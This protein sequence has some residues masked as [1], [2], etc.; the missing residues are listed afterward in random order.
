MKRSPSFS[1]THA[2]IHLIGKG[3]STFTPITLGF[4]P[5]T[6]SMSRLA[7]GSIFDNQLHINSFIPSSV[8]FFF[9]Y[10]L[11]GGSFVVL[12][13]FGWRTRGFT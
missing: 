12:G 3:I 13:Q 4:K 6:S 7:I 8:S 9:P 1:I 10:F 5:K 2:M 11:S